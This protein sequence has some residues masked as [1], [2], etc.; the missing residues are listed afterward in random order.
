MT[1]TLVA[2]TAALTLAGCPD[3][4]PPPPENAT[5]EA[6]S[7]APDAPDSILST[8]AADIADAAD[9]TTGEET[10]PSDAGVNPDSGDTAPGDTPPQED[11]PDPADAATT[12]DTSDATPPPCACDDANPCTDDACD[13]AGLCVATNNT[14]PCDDADACTTADSCAEGSC[15]GT[16]PLPCDDQD[17]CTTDSCD[18]AMGCTVSAVVCDDEDACTTDSCDPATGC[19]VSAV[20]CDDGDACTTDA[21]DSEAGCTVSAVVCDVGDA[22]TTDSCDPATGCTVSA[23]VCDDENACTTDSC[24]PATGCTVSALVCDDGDACTTDACNRVTGCTVSAVVCDD[25]DMC[26]TDGCAPATGC[27]ISAVVC[28]DGD[29]CTV[30]GCDSGSGCTVSALVCDDADVCT[31]DSCKSDS[32]CLHVAPPETAVEAWA[33]FT[34]ADAASVSVGPNLLA[35]GD[36]SEIGGEPFVGWA[37]HGVGWSSSTVAHLAPPA[38]YVTA[39]DAVTWAGAAQVVSLKQEVAKPLLVTGWARAADVGAGASNSTFGAYLDVLYGDGTPLWGQKLQFGRG[40]H[41]WQYRERFV[42]VEKPVDHVNAHLMLRYAPGQ[43]WFDDFGLHEVEQPIFEFDGVTVV[44]VGDGAPDEPACLGL[45]TADGSLALSL[46]RFGALNALTA[47]G[48]DVL[49]PVS[50]GRSGL[51]VRDHAQPGEFVHFAGIVATGDGAVSQA[52]AALGLELDATWTAHESHISVSGTVSG[53]G[54]T[55]RLLTVYLA[56]PVGTDGWQWSHDARTDVTVTGTHINASVVADPEPIGATGSASRYPFGAVSGPEAGVAIGYPMHTPRF[57]RIFQHADAG[58]LVIAVDIALSPLTASPQTADFE[59][60]IYSFEPQWRFRAAL[61]RYY[62]LF[63]ELFVKR[64]A[65]EG[66]WYAFGKL[67]SLTDVADFGIAYHEVNNSAAVTAYDDSIGVYTLHY[68]MEPN[69]SWMLLDPSVDTSDDAAVLTA[70]TALAESGDSKAIATLASAIE[71]VDGALSIKAC[72]GQSWCAHGAR[73]LINSDPGIAT[74]QWPLSWTDHHWS[75]AA[76]APYLAPTFG[77]LDGEYIDSL[78]GL[79]ARCNYRASHFSTASAPLV[80]A[81]ETQKPCVLNA[82]SNY[83]GSRAVLDDVLEYDRLRMS[84]VDFQRFSF[85]AHLLD[86][87]GLERN[88]WPAGAWKP[89]SDEKMIL[90]RSVMGQKPYGLLMNTDMT[91]VS[92]AEVEQYMRFM[93]FY[94][95]FPSFFVN[96]AGSTYWADGYGDRDRALFKQ[97]VPL[98]QTIAGAGWQPITLATTPNPQLHVERFGDGPTFFTV[99]NITDKPAELQ[100]LVD[101]SLVTDDSTA[102]EL[103]DGASATLSANVLTATIP[104]QT[105]QLYRISP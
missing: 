76:K 87:A 56:V 93:L 92:T 62:D 80:W 45:E 89:D 84:N 22:C 50:A 55:P 82:F 30:D 53:N 88:F 11:T 17:A 61:Q 40:T 72:T 69:Y 73:I 54:E 18:P 13:E 51:F 32:G 66:L 10:T 59:F 100:L 58:L 12:T 75:D 37:P 23:V 2:A 48:T 94:G 39:A 9:P 52:G 102:T 6:T 33:V 38:A 28:D 1:L 64:V 19:T 16:A 29:A 97:Y 15:Q 21:C 24:D 42:F 20:V 68:T 31:V 91:Q 60:V 57:A 103:L 85:S 8:D 65:A 90:R 105:V 81:R 70:V 35:N 34:G 5:G 77:E 49:D 86:T 41:G 67:D 71:D 74:P 46:S 78:N 4:P 95:F 104:P 26:T 83:Q 79:E 3:P 98:I 27:T 101:S 25:E 47:L 43:G 7:G 36:F 96:D 63:A 14:A 44:E 99:H